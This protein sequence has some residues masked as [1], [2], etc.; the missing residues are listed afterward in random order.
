MLTDC[1]GS[2]GSGYTPLDPLLNGLV[3]PEGL[4]RIGLAAESTSDVFIQ[5]IDQASGDHVTDSEF[6]LTFYGLD[7]VTS[8][9]VPPGGMTKFELSE[10][11]QISTAETNGA[12]TFLCLPDDADVVELASIPEDPLQLSSAQAARAVCIHFSGLKQGEL[13]LTVGDSDIG[14]NFLFSGVSPFSA[15]A[16]MR[17]SE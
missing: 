5:F 8:I 17:V 4:C 14:R 11:T 7:A 16:C 2:V 9:L 6:V 12:T 3:Q 13:Q 10:N 1:C 15:G